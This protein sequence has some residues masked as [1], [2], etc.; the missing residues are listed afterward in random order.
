[1]A[2]DEDDPPWDTSD[3]PAEILRKEAQVTADALGLEADHESFDKAAEFLDEP[4]KIPSSYFEGE[5]IPLHRRLRDLRADLWVLAKKDDKT[6]QEIN[7]M[8]LLIGAAVALMGEAARR[9]DS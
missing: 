4:V 5:H 9:L 3:N 6:P 2:S 7:E 1:M 8:H